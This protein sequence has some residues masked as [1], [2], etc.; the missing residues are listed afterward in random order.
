MKNFHYLGAPG[1]G[2]VSAT[3]SH[4]LRIV[5]SGSSTVTLSVYIDGTLQGTVTDSS[6]TLTTPGS[7][8]ALIGDGTPA[9]SAVTEWQDY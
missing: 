8:F 7:G 5:A 3:V 1:C 9:D 2:A 4:T 6:S